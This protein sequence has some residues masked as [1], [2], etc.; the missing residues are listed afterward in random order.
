MISLGVF[1]TDVD[2]DELAAYKNRVRTLTEATALAH[3]KTQLREEGKW[4]P[5]TK[6]DATGL[7]KISELQTFLRDA[8]FLPFAKIDGICGYR[9]LGGIFLFQ[10]Y[11]RTVEGKTDLGF[12]DGRFGPRSLQHMRRW[13]AAGQK[14]GWAA[15]SSASPAPEYKQWLALLNAF[16]AHYQ[17]SPT[18]TMQKVSAAK[19]CDTLKVA[20]WNYDPEKIHLLGIRHRREPTRD[21]EQRMDDA[22]VLLIRGLVF[23]FYG[24]TEPGTMEGTA[25]YPFLVA[26]QHRYR[27]GWHKQ[28]NEVRIFQGLR[29]RGNGVWVQRAKTRF[30]TAAEMAGRLDGPNTTINVHWGGDV[31]IDSAAWSAGCQ[32]I[33]G[34]GYINHQ[35]KVV[36]CSRFTARG[37]TMLG[38]L[39]KDKVYLSKGAYT[40]LEHL[41]AAFSGKNPDDNIVHY[42]LLPET[43]LALTPAPGVAAAQTLVERLKA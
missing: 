21:G 35:D 30:P 36:D 2:A 7:V 9:T 26:G 24:S 11:I 3:W 33:S 16:R 14:A 42:T 40:V 6:H 4:V 23:K 31:T 29:P 8:G 41:V 27:F 22:F 18:A 17:A 34:K 19:A 12:P 5:Y 39:D 28:S 38:R 32:V 25:G 20:D 13:Q 1:D 37:Y 15:I 10:E 43:D